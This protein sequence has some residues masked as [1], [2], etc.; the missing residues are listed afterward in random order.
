MT[1]KGNFKRDDI[2]IEDRTFFLVLTCGPVAYDLIEQCGGTTRY[3]HAACRSV[4]L[5]CA[6][7][8]VNDPHYEATVTER[9]RRQAAEAR[10]ERRAG[11]GAYRGHV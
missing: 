9:L 1:T 4:R 6:S 8:F 5:A 10:A 7:D 2:V 3:R 11:A